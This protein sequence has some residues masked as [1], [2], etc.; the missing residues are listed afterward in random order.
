LY[1]KLNFQWDEVHDVAE[2]LE[3]VKSSILIDRLEAFLGF[4]KFDPHGDPIPDKDG[5]LQ[6]SESTTLSEM[7]VGENGLLI[8]VGNDNPLLLQYLDRHEIK[9]GMRF[10]V[11]EK[12][13]FD[14]SVNIVFQ[15]REPM[16]VS[17]Q[18]A[19]QLIVK[20]IV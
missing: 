7:K 18:V 19:S 1:D 2:Q 12:V 6:D 14:D 10:K 15:K 9:L 3:H 16:F 20:E 17:D 13:A 5:N 8:G 4:P 11:L